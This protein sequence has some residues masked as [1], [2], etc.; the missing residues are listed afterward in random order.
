MSGELLSQMGNVTSMTELF[1]V[2]VIT[3]VEVVGLP[4]DPNRG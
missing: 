4:K 3:S 1:I 2:G